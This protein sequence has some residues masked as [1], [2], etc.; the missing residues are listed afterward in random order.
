L[1]SRDEDLQITPEDSN[2]D[3]TSLNPGKGAVLRSPRS[4]KESKAPILTAR[5]PD[6][7]NDTAPTTANPPR[8]AVPQ[9]PFSSSGLGYSGIDGYLAELDTLIHRPRKPY[10]NGGRGQGESITFSSRSRDR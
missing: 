1:F 2:A 8:K 10:E 4:R 5:T 9:A 6:T 7:S 3:S